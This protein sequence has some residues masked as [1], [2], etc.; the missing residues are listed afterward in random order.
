[1]GGF[2]ALSYAG[3]NDV[4][5]LALITTSGA[6]RARRR[7]DPHTGRPRYSVDATTG[8]DISTVYEATRW[9][10]DVETSTITAPA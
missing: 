8:N 10:L 2:A 3:R 6:E 5:A 1:V 7:R 9:T 4:A